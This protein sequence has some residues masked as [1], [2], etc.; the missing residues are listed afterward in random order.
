[1]NQ[2]LKSNFIATLARFNSGEL[3]VTEFWSAVEGLQKSGLWEQ[4]EGRDEKAI[5]DFLAWYLDMYDPARAPRPGVVGRMR[6]WVSEIGGEY[7][8]GIEE[9]RKKAFDLERV[10]GPAEHPTPER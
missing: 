1:M 9:L 8:V 2:S 4:L 5:S 7:R 10:L 6:D 3:G